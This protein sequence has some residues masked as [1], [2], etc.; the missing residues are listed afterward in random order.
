[1]AKKNNK[2][3][4][5]GHRDAKTGRFVT[6]TYAQQNPDTTI[7]QHLPVTEHQPK[8]TEQQ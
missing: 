8:P 5:V 7:K 4:R 3:T 6:S 2:K 1:M